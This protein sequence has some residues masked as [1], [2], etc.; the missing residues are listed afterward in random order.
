MNKKI[1]C[2]FIIFTSFFVIPNANAQW[3]I[4]SKDADSLVKIGSDYVYNIEFEKARECFK[5]VQTKYPIHPAGYFLDAMIEWWEINMFIYSKKTE[6][7]FLKK[8][9]YVIALCDVELKKDPYNISALFFK[10]GALGYRGR[11]YANKKEWFSA[12]SDGKDAFEIMAKCY[13]TA[14]GNHD[15]VLG[16]GIYNYFAEAIP[17]KM[18]ALKAIVLFFPKG[19]KKL[20]IMQLKA[21]ALYARYTRIEAKVVLWQAFYSFEENANES[22]Y[23]SRDLY[24]SYP[25]NP[26]FHRCYAR[27]LVK[28]GEWDSIEFVWRNVVNRALSR[29]KGYDNA[30]ARE[31]CYYVGLALERK[32]D[33]EK[34]IKYL[35]KA[36][37]V[38]KYIQDDESGF[39]ISS[40]YKLGLIYDKMNKR[41]LAIKQY[42]AV[43]AMNDYQGIHEKAKQYM[44]VAYR[45]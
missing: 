5:Q 39:R 7:E 11:F 30:M 35:A 38:S 18:P 12:G 31:G 40:Q 42:K 44:K 21:A 26:Y 19:N 10:G 41:D 20:G 36:E 8:I 22:V 6:D 9:N 43:L 13:E 23:Y 25:N 15:I 28:N 24:N 37:E 33:F 27:S 29:Q 17:E 1:F 45:E 34:A 32:K 2:F 3:V 4:M 14:P 16:T